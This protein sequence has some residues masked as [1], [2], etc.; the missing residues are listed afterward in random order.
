MRLCHE[1]WLVPHWFLSVKRWKKNLSFFFTLLSLQC[2]RRWF[3]GR[4]RRKTAWAWL[5]G[6]VLGF[7]VAASSP[8]SLKVAL[9]RPPATFLRAQIR[10]STI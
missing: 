10:V 2:C 6:V 9:P 1:P 4:T 7:R 5:R 8:L 3:L